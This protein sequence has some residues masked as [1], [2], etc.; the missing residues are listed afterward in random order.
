MIAI[1]V[2][3]FMRIY[4]KAGKISFTYYIIPKPIEINS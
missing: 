4:N 1:M 2:F 3:S